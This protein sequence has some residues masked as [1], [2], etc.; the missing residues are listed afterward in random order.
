MTT[1]PPGDDGRQP[2]AACARASLAKSAWR[3]TVRARCPSP[4]RSAA[5]R[6]AARP[7]SA[8]SWSPPL[9]PMPETGRSP[10]PPRRP[11][12][13]AEISADSFSI[14]AGRRRRRLTRGDPRVVQPVFV[15]RARCASRAAF[16]RAWPAVASN[17]RPL[18]IAG[19]DREIAYCRSWR[20]FPPRRRPRRHQQGDPPAAA[21]QHAQGARVVRGIPVFAAVVAVAV[22]FGAGWRGHM[23]HEVPSY[24][25]ADGAD[26]MRHLDAS[27]AARARAT[28]RN[29]AATALR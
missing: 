3:A 23:G 8:A 12:G 25:E 22:T 28:R 19:D 5:R 18:L 10:A 9:M 21:A 14:A 27:S 6:C 13:V 4:R 2:S 16:R 24:L 17:A 29:L 15:R 1:S 7:S 26:V 11:V 20:S